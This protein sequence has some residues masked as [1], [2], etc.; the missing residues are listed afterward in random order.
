MKKWLIMSVTTVCAVS[1]LAGCTPGNNT[2]GATV[3]GAAAGGLLGAALFSGAG[4]WMGVAAGALIGGV[5]GNQIGQHMDRQ[6]EQNMQRAIT[7]VPVGEQASW[8]NDKDITYV[9]R[10]VKQYHSKGRYCRE[11]KTSIKIDGQWKRAFGKA[12][13]MPD[14]AW[15]VVS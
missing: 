11:Y 6:D 10:P 15:K 5:I 4:G 9:V 12:C 7:T 14:G 8:T 2:T 3:T 1:L 13:R